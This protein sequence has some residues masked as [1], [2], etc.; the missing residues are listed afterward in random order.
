MSSKILEA[1]TKLFALITKQDGGATGVERT[2]V[3]KYFEKELDENSVGHYKKMYDDEAEYGK[4]Q[5]N[6]LITMKDS[7]RILRFC[8]EINKGLEQAQKVI[9]LVKLLELVASDKSDK[10]FTPQRRMIIDTVSSA[11]NIKDDYSDIEN[12]VMCE[13]STILSS[14]D[15]LVASDSDKLISPVA[16]YFKTDNLQGE[17]IFK[18]V[19]S[20]D[21]YFVK[22]LGEDDVKLNGRTMER[23]EISQFY[24][25]SVIRLPKG[26]NIYYGDITSIFL[27]NLQDVKL[28]FIARALEFKFPSGAIGV[29]KLHL[30]EPKGRL[31]GIMG[32][33]GA[34]KTTLMNVLAAIESPSSGEVLI[35]GINIHKDKDKIEGVIGFIAQ[36]DLL[37]EELTVYQNLYY[38]AK[39]C[40]KDL[41]EK[42]IDERVMNTLK[43]LGLDHI[44]HLKVGNVLN[45]KI[46]GGQRKR[47]NI[48]L[49]LIREP[50]V[51]FVDE[52]TSGLSSKDSQN[53]IDLLKEL[54]LK[55]KLIFVVIHQP[56]SD[57]YKTFDKMIILDKGGYLI[58][59]GNPIEAISYFKRQTNQANA[60]KWSENPEEMFQIIEKEVV[61]EFGIETGVRQINP[62][63]WHERYLAKFKEAAFEEVEEVKEEP[64]KSLNRPNV[65]KQAFI[66]TIRDFLAKVSNQQYMLIN[67][68]EAPVLAVLLAYIIRF[69]NEPKT[70]DYV[71]R[72]NDNVPA[73]VLI[74]IIIS[75]FMGLTVSAEEIIKDRKI[76]KREQFLNLSRFGYLFSKIFILFLLSAVQTLSFVVIGNAILQIEWSLLFSYWGVLFSVS[77]FANMLGLNISAMFNSVIT[78]YITIPLLLIPQMI[79][80]GIIFKYEK[81]NKVV[82]ERGKVPVLA[83]FMT[84]RWA[85]EAII[86][87]HYKNNSYE[88]DYY[89]LDKKISQNDYRV[90]YWIPE[91]KG[92]IEKTFENTNLKDKKDSIKKEINKNLALIKK[93]IQDEKAYMKLLK[94]FDL[95]KNLTPEKFDENARN[96]LIDYLN[97]IDKKFNER[98]NDASKKK[99]NAVDILKKDREKK[100]IKYDANEYKDKYFNDGLFNFVT[101]AEMLDKIIEHKG[102]LLQQSDP[103]YKDPRESSNPLDYR[104][105][106]LSPSKPFLGLKFETYYFNVSVIWLFTF[107]FYITL[108]FNSFKWLMDISGKIKLKKKE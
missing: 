37:I 2:F 41:T 76:Q 16:K 73:Y 106:F 90:T 10:S 78:I 85:F 8:R 83:D 97:T 82:S 68:L 25:G 28:S 93:E 81:M 5:D 9:I 23:Q 18:W 104:T 48:A 65:I 27:E 66:F 87:N 71:F 61:N 92:R 55:G 84:S 69:Q 3:I 40:F 6:K 67:L 7:V 21:M 96:T 20:V 58:Y 49:E 80:S 26:G 98:K 105:H 31:L 53:V 34:G 56:S 13:G 57:I 95:D 62:Q 51:M 89:S 52:P 22:Y 54:S 11:F 46:S 102:E 70:D 91:L 79:L 17:I 43:N 47:L 72:Y 64:P 101:N 4:V 33:S 1:L 15:I 45:K 75:L 60:E 29:Q 94:D 59:Y 24:K 14:S 44:H 86:V 32:G 74:C 30:S 39:L 42:E 77:C 99:D 50:A 100:G 12:F 103:I 35:N 36:D 108:Y 63:Q 88:K 107:I 38:N 19:R